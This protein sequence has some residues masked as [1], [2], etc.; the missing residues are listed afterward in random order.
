MS[1]ERVRELIQRYRN[2]ILEIEKTK[3]LV[4]VAFINNLKKCGCSE[5]EALEIFLE[6]SIQYMRARADTT[7]E[8]GI[9]QYKKQ[10]E[11]LMS[12]LD[13]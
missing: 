3:K 4:N 1:N 8:K 13:I 2:D 6:V 5:K 9:E 10:I 12:L 7:C 11:S